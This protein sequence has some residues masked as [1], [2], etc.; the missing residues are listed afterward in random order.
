MK[1]AIC[2]VAL[3]VTFA[4]TSLYAAGWFDYFVTV[5]KLPSVKTQTGGWVEQAAMYVVAVDLTEHHPAS[6][7]TDGYRL[8]F[9]G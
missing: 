3:L 8:E 7:D 4:A 9:K 6:W 5:G 1:T 2:R